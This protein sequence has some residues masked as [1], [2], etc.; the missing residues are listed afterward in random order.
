MGGKAARAEQEGQHHTST[1]HNHLRNS[2][3]ILWNWAKLPVSDYEYRKEVAQ[4][5]KQLFRRE[6]PF[7]GVE[8]LLCNLSITKTGDE[9]GSAVRIEKVSMIRR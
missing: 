4:H 1:S 3:L 9:S 6:T 2:R 5:Q 7:P 8:E